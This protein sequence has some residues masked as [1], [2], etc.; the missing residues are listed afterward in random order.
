MTDD[1]QSVNVWQLRAGDP[2]VVNGGWTNRNTFQANRVNVASTYQTMTS[3]YGSSN[4]V[5][6]IVQDVNRGLNYVTVRDEATGQSV[7]I[8][9]RRMDTRRSVNVW[10]LHAG[11]RIGVNGTWED[12]DTFQADTVNF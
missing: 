3:A 12:R 9:V 7:K 8:D 6:G 2:V 10:N 1:R 11:D 4:F 5:N